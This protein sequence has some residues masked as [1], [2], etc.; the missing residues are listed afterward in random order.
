MAS[1]KPLVL[2]VGATGF[3]G[4]S[5]VKGLLDSGNFVRPVPFRLG[6]P[7]EDV[8]L[9]CIHQ[10]VAAL[11]RPTSISKPVVQG[12]RASGVEIR[13][14]DVHDSA[15]QLKEALA[16]V[17]ILI[18][19]VDGKLVAHQVNL[20]RAAAEVDTIKRVIPCDFGPPVKRGVR[21]IDSQKFDIRDLIKELGLPYTFI[22]VGWWMQLSLPLPARSKVPA[23]LK[24][25]TYEL[26]GTG[27][28]KI[29]LSDHRDIGVYVARILADTRTLNKLVIVW[30]DEQT[31]EKVHEIGEHF[32]GEADNLKAKGL[33]TV[34]QSGRL[35]NLHG[36]YDVTLGRSQLG[37][38]ARTSVTLCDCERF[39]A[40]SVSAEFSGISGIVHITREL[41]LTGSRPGPKRTYASAEEI[42]KR[43]AEGKADL[44][45]D[46]SNAPAALKV[47]WH[48]YMYSLHIAGE[49]TLEN[50][51]HLG[52][53]DARELYPDVPRRS[54][55]EFAKE[56]YSL[57]EPGLEY[58][59]GD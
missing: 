59:R 20:F 7:G 21:E 51:K 54:L 8:E 15:P 18:S 46:P 1:A 56:Y 37:V 47:L 14:G 26:H 22:D 9:K 35:P 52:Y 36:R 32:S 45:K 38:H 23:V 58:L 34:E 11:V 57:E 17:E 19:A 40:R 41:N 28:Q 5:I 44:V 33:I 50:A 24:Q 39:G 25:W 30:E 49:N 27:T 10:R 53:L 48:D 43:I 3:T 12:L 31:E 55:E 42:A 13:T 16:G 6:A 29:L 2:V 4:S